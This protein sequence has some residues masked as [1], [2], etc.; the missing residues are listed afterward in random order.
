M[1]LLYPLT[2]L[3]Q[4]PMPYPSAIFIRDKAL[5]V[6][7]ESMRLIICQDEVLV[8]SVPDADHPAHPAFPTPDGAFVKDLVQRVSGQKLSFANDHNLHVDTSLPYE[9]RALEAVLARGVCT[10]L[11]FL[12]LYLPSFVSV[13]AN[14][15]ISA[16]IPN[17]VL[18]VVVNSLRPDL[19]YC[20]EPNNKLAACE[21]Y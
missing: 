5:V 20:V 18:T 2:A 21:L 12:R 4:V 1:L 9:L 10:Y 3:L 14:G 8:L 7:V 15:A 16:A 19:C 11:P 13:G 17:P 6:N